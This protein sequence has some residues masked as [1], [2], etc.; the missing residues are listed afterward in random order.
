DS[1]IYMCF[2]LN[3]FVPGLTLRS[4]KF[5]LGVKPQ[6]FRD[7]SAQVTAF[8]EGA[9]TLAW[10]DFDKDGDQDLFLAKDHGNNVLMRNKL[11]EQ[12]TLLFEDVTDEFL[13]NQGFGSSGGIWG[14][15][16]NNGFPDLLIANNSE[17]HPNQLFLNNGNG[18]FLESIIPGLFEKNNDAGILN[19]FDVNNDSKLDVYAISLNPFYDMETW[20]NQFYLAQ[21][22]GSFSTNY[23]T[24]F[25]ELHYS[26]RN[27]WFDYSND[28]KIDVFFVDGAVTPFR[29][30]TNS[31][32]IEDFSFYNN[33]G[34]DAPVSSDFNNDGYL[35]LFIGCTGSTWLNEPISHSLLKNISGKTMIHLN[36]TLTRDSMD[37]NSA[38]WGD[39]DNDGDLD[40]ICLSEFGDFVLW[41]NLLQEQGI[42]DFKRYNLDE[43]YTPFRN[44]KAC[45]FVDY[46]ND[47]DLDFS[48]A[49]DNQCY[50]F[51]NLVGSSNN[52][53]EMSLKGTLS[54]SSAYGTKVKVKANIN[55]RDCWQT[56]EVTSL[57]NRTTSSPSVTMFGLGNATVI[58]SVKIYWPSGTYWD[59]TN[60]Q[61]NQFIEFVEHEKPNDLPQMIAL[62]DTII[63]ENVPFS[64]TY[65]IKDDWNK[66]I[67]MTVSKLPSWLKF[68][69]NNRLLNLS[70]LPN[71][72]SPGDYQ[73]IFSVDDGYV[74]KPV[75]DTL[76]I[77]VVNVND[78]PIIFGQGKIEMPENGVL[79][80]EIGM[81]QCFDIDNFLSELSVRIHDGN[82]YTVRADS[83]L[84]NQNYFYNLSVPIQLFDGELYSD[85]FD[86]EIINNLNDIPCLSLTDHH[87]YAVEDEYFET[88]IQVV[89]SRFSKIEV[90]ELNHLGWL[91]CTLK[92]QTIKLSGTPENNDTGFYTYVL[93]LDDGYLENPIKDTLFI[94]VENVNDAPVITGQHPASFD[95][96]GRFDFSLDYLQV[97]DVDN[98]YPMDFGFSMQAGNNYRLEGNSIFYTNTDNSLVELPI[99]VHDG[100]LHSN[101]WNFTIEKASNSTELL[102]EQIEL[103]PIPFVNEL[104]LVVPNGLKVNSFSFYNVT[105]QRVYPEIIID[106]HHYLIDFTGCSQEFILMNIVLNEKVIT[107]KLMRIPN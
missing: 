14:D 26:Y 95:V 38:C 97:E 106:N 34:K 57:V 81:M 21:P 87:L 33:Y 100:F 70:G 93:E 8:R 62:N 91:S 48:M 88:E 11:F 22:D 51:E 18:T 53:I 98:E 89:D 63:F 75:V 20:K 5:L 40:L 56:R 50:L 66:G 2:M 65:N 47:G 101:T 76:N 78:P 6:L 44:A 60:V 83:I 102:N 1:G 72:Y 73:L 49:A 82:G 15:I 31:F 59:T 25:F 4:D 77:Q 96:D 42:E 45:T 92:N 90:A 54:N 23:L 13:V 79:I 10:C 107:K 37:I 74:I 52:W 94:T 68:Q 103:Y 86:L 27:T 43:F 64:K 7:V 39:Y 55:G 17:E 69:Y 35:D 67:N 32:S 61:I 80:L 104:H 16:D 24:D 3:E 85:T 12:D 58:D 41:I 36:N 84:L 99:Q 9:N 46:D 29:N 19:L 28:G 71:D 30:L 105:G